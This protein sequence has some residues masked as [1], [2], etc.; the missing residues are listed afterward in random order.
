MKYRRDCTRLV[1]WLNPRWTDTGERNSARR[2][3][4]KSLA[5]RL[6]VLHRV[7]PQVQKEGCGE[8]LGRRGGWGPT[9]WN[10]KQAACKCNGQ[11]GAIDG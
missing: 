7:R 8:L 2:E 9:D 1:C 6:G 5:C 10:G 3:P 4:P 11:M